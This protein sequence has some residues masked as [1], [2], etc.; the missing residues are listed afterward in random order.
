MPKLKKTHS[1]HMDISFRAAYAN[2]MEIM[3]YKRQQMVTWLGVSGT[4]ERSRRDRPGDMT[5][6]ELRIFA[7]KLKFTPQQVCNIVGIPYK[8]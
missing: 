7:N 6:D 3:E 8:E 1:E 2:N 4:T 5:L